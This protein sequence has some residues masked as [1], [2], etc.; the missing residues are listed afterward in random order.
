[1]AKMHRKFQKDP[2]IIYETMMDLG[3]EP[4]IHE[5]GRRNTVTYA[6][7][8]SRETRKKLTCSRWS[9]PY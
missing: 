8:E 2:I 3:C 1:M 6:Y 4:R 9:K 5:S 7:D